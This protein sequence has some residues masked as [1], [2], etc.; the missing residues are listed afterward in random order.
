M[1]DDICVARGRLGPGFD[2]LRPLA[3]RAKGGEPIDKAILEKSEA[4]VN[5]PAEKGYR[6]PSDTVGTNPPKANSYHL[7]SLRKVADYL[8]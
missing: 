4:R 6:T 3:S 5:D 7:K 2:W 8:T 1:V